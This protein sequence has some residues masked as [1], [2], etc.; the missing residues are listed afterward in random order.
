[1]KLSGK[2][3]LVTGGGSG[4]GRAAT[5]ALAG[6]GAQVVA[7]GRRETLLRETCAAIASDPPARYLVMD[8]GNR[9]QVEAGVT[10]VTETFGAIHLVVHSA[11]VNVRKRRM[12]ELSPED[13]DRVMQINVTGAFN[14]FHAV[15][16]QMRQRRDGLIINISSI[17]GLRASPLGGAAYSASKHALN[18]LGL[19]VAQEEKENGIRVT[20]L[21]P[22]EINTP[23]LDERPVQVSAEHRAQI[24][25]PEDVAAAVLF[26]ASLPPRVHVPELIIKPTIQNFA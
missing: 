12:A 26:V 13:W 6:E 24:L 1:M 2:V 11:G 14:I 17:A 7:I 18:A 22:G 25:Q 20:N 21:C 8:V 9:R 23:L 10:W 15:L 3:A 16:S 5:A 4:V 19:A